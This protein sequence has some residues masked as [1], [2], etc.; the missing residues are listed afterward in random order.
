[1]VLIDPAIALV[2]RW[3][4][5]FV[6]ALALIHKLRSPAAFAATLQ[7][8]RLLPAAISLPAAWILIAMES[9][10]VAG[11]VS[12]TPAG[13]LL[14]ALL[15]CVYTAAI[16]INLL[17]GRRDIDCGCSGPAMRQTLSVWLVARNVGL[18]AMA[19]VTFAPVAARSLT[20]LDG[21]TVLSAL[22]TFALIYA[23]ANRLNVTASRFT[24][25]QQR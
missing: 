19:T 7:N 6:F 20:W 13:C 16:A 23:S 17:R 4:L 15:L 24:A 22:L 8:Y 9:I 5:T 2:A 21:L 10:A 3:L 11:L 14:A 12:G 1:M 25:S 18:I